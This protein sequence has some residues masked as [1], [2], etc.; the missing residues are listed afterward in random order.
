[1]ALNFASGQY[2][3]AGS[4]TSLDELATINTAFTVWAWVYRTS[5]GGNQH[6][7]TKDGSFPSGWAFICDNSPGEGTLR[8][9]VFKTSTGSNWADYVSVAGQIPLNTWTFVA[10]Y[11]S[12]DV[13][14]AST[15]KLYVGGLG[16]NAAEPTYNL[17]QAGSNGA[18][19]TD[20][21]YNLYV[22]NLQRATTFPFLGRIARA[23]VVRRALTVDEIRQIQFG[24]IPQCNVPNTLMLL[25][26]HGTGTQND[27]SGNGN[28]GA[29]TSATVVDHAPLVAPY[30]PE[31][32]AVVWQNAGGGGSAPLDAVITAAASLSGALTVDKPLAAAVTA[33]ASLVAAL[34][35]AKPLVAAVTAQASIVAALTVDK[36]LAS[37]ITAQASLAAALTVDKPLNATVSA[38]AALAGSLTVDKPLATSVTAQASLVADLTV[39][40]PLAA[41]VT[42][43]ASVVADLTVA[44]PLA[45]TV[46]AVASLLADLTAA[47]AGPSLASAV[48]ASASLVADLTVA[49][50]LA[51]VITAQGAI[52]AVL[53][54][55]KP[56][57]AVIGANA[58]LVANLTIPVPITSGTLIGRVTILPAR[59]GL[60]TVQSAHRGNVSVRAALSALVEVEP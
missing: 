53:T 42:A 22:G 1:M 58:V 59:F 45:A 11:H 29:V 38:S 20:A 50:P 30:G 51:V 12:S 3:N 41:A 10:A 2:V 52:V 5:N 9:V 26:L 8:F 21:A 4:A 44:K 25:D 34:T 36:P 19:S 31:E 13:A 16:T 14:G 27:H 43:Q 33:Q 40:K 49:K 54:V 6:I 37:A 28:T 32:W 57:A 23:G 55:P 24:T 60:V 47:G 48:S 7:M 39:A 46:T 18:P 15:M 17:Q 56:L 35:V